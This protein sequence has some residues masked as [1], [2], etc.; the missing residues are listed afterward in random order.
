MNGAY[1]PFGY[2][3]DLLSA[4]GGPRKASV[5]DLGGAQHKSDDPAPQVGVDYSAS[6][7]DE[8]NRH[9]AGLERVSSICRVWVEF[10][11]VTPVIAAVAALAPQ[12]DGVNVN[13]ST[14]TFTPTLASTGEVEIVWTLGQLAPQTRRPGAC[15]HSPVLIGADKMAS[16]PTGKDGVVVTMLDPTNPANGINADFYVEIHG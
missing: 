6:E 13:V 9:I 15:A 4:D 11:G 1:S 14:S 12:G 5:N 7:N 3:H 8:Q 16:P 2:T 10:S